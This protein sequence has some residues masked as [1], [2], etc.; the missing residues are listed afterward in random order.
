[1]LVPPSYV[2]SN[3]LCQSNPLIL[4]LILVSCQSCCQSHNLLVT[5][6]TNG[7]GTERNGHIALYIGFAISAYIAVNLLDIPRTC[8]N[9]RLRQAR[10]PQL[11][12]FSTT[13]LYTDMHVTYIY[14]FAISIRVPIRSDINT[15]HPPFPMVGKCGLI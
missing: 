3:L 2:S 8:H 15:I 13:N 14:A 1:M 9:R 10:T 5:L 6:G 12:F 11:L 7:Y 4:I